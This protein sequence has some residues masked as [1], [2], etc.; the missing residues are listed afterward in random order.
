[1]PNRNPNRLNRRFASPPINAQVGVS[2]FAGPA[3]PMRMLPGFAQYKSA[4]DGG[5]LVGS[6]RRLVGLRAILISF[7][8]YRL[9]YRYRLLL[10]SFARL[11][12]NGLSP[13]S[14]TKSMRYAVLQLVNSVFISGEK[15]H[16]NR[17]YLTPLKVAKSTINRICLMGNS[18]S[19]AVVRKVLNFACQGIRSGN[20]HFYWF[21]E[22]ECTSLGQ[23]K[24]SKSI[25]SAQHNKLVG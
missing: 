18:N 19:N 13:I 16:I 1:M 2:E 14:P 12:E 4:S 11:R 20:V 3:A 24:K 7:Y 6:R 15:V 21:L 17:P 5:V 8:T 23:N 25:S 9:L 22:N 10:L